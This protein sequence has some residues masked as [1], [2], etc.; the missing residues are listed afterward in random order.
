M[1]IIKRSD[2]WFGTELGLLDGEFD[3]GLP[4][5]KLLVYV[6]LILKFMSVLR[7]QLIG[8]QCVRLWKSE[9]QMSGPSNRILCCCQRLCTAAT[10]FE[11]AVLPAGAMTHK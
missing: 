4:L 3:S 2:L 10:F 8:Q 6:V 9:V 7:V 11:G 5:L 1:T